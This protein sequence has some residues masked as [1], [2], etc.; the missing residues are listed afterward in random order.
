M[1]LSVKRIYSVIAWTGIALV[2]VGSVPAFSIS[3]AWITSPETAGRV[4]E[5]VIVSVI[6]GILGFLLAMIAG[7]LAKNRRVSLGII[8]AG[9]VYTLAFVPWI[10]LGNT[11]WVSALF[12]GV[13]CIIGGFVMLAKRHSGWRIRLRY[14]IA[15]IMVPIVIIAAIIGV[16]AIIHTFFAPGFLTAQLQPPEVGSGEITLV[17]GSNGGSYRLV[18]NE[19]D[20]YTWEYLRVSGGSAGPPRK[21]KILPLHNSENI[22]LEQISVPG[23]KSPESAFPGDYSGMGVYR[24]D[25]G[26]WGISII[27]TCV[28]V[29]ERG[30]ETRY[31]VFRLKEYVPEE[32]MVLEYRYLQPA[33]P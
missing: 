10:L 22:P 29:S 19:K 4:T 5:G 31:V 15:T 14:V 7:F 17:V 3:C 6:L 18:T 25:T 13:L 30:D 8:I 23:V 24:Y 16:P 27:G 2:L 33:A 28:T 26:W 9:G 11:E 1:G 20:A 21:G 12:P 32:R